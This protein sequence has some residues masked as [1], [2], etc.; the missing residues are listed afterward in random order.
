VINDIP[1]VKWN[2]HKSY[3][4]ELQAKGAHMAKT[5]WVDRGSRADV[6]A[7][8][9]ALKAKRMV[10]KPCVAAT[11]YETF[12]MDAIHPDQTRFDEL[13]SNHDLIV[14]EFIEEVQTLGEWSLIFFDG[15]FSHA[16]IK[17][18][19]AD[20]FRVQNDFGGTYSQAN[21]PEKILKQA[22]EVIKALPQRLAYA[23]VDGV[24][25]GDNFLLMELELIEPA[26]FL[27]VDFLA[28]KR[29]SEAIQNSL[30]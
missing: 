28:P 20:D 6:C 27:S 13:I 21:P 18:P 30:S 25:S 24:M 17:K 16:V 12:V 10:A 19:K 3:L 26:L 14:Q 22:S 1:T 5:I 15:K 9:E 8:A 2:M 4:K 29:L 23:R 11:A 7:L